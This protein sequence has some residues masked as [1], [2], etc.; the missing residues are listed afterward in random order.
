[1]IKNIKLQAALLALAAAVNLC[2]NV[3]AGYSDVLGDAAEYLSSGVT[4]AAGQELS[5][6]GGAAISWS[7]IRNNTIPDENGAYETP[8]YLRPD[9]SVITPEWFEGDIKLIADAE[10]SLNGETAFVDDVSITLKSESIPQFSA[11]ELTS[12]INIGDPESEAAAGF[13]SVRA[14]EPETNTACG[15]SE[16]F[17]RLSKNGSMALTLKCDGSKT[18]YF[19]VKLWGGDTENAMLWIVDNTTEET[20]GHIDSANTRG[21]SRNSL[22][23]RND[24]VELNSQNSETPQYGG[25]FIYSTY[26]IPRIYT[27]GREYVTIRLYSTG[28]SSDYSTPKIKEQTADSRGIY[29][30]YMGTDPCFDP[31]DFG[32]AVSGI[33]A[34]EPDTEMTPLED[35]HSTVSELFWSGVDSF[36]SWQIYGG[37]NY[38]PYM[39]GMQTRASDWRYKSYS[40]TDWKSAY[41]TSGRMLRQNITPLNMFEVFAQTYRLLP[42]GDAEKAELLDRIIKGVDFLARAQGLNGGWYSLNGWIGGGAAERTPDNPDG[43]LNAG[44][45]HLEGFGVRSAGAAVI[46]LYKEIGPYLSEMI[47]SDADGKADKTRYE[48]WEEMF[49]RAWDFYTSYDGAGHAPNQDMAQLIAALRFQYCLKLMDSDSLRSDEEIE[50]QINICLGKDLSKALSSYWV[51]PKGLILENF[52][53]VQ[54]GYSGDY[55]TNALAELSQAAEIGSAFFPENASE[56]ADTVNAAYDAAGNF[57]FTS[58]VSGAPVQYAEG[59]ISTRNS[60]YPG[61]ERYICDPYA[62]LTLNNKTSLK[63][64]YNEFAFDRIMLGTDEYSPSNAHFED[65]IVSLG[66]YLLNWDEYAAAFEEQ[67]ISEYDFISEDGDIDQYAWADEM[68]RNVVIK[69]AGETLYMALNWRSPMH[70]SSNRTVDPP[71]FYNSEGSNGEQLVYANNIGRVHHKSKGADRYGYFEVTTA[72]EYWSQSSNSSWRAV[73]YHYMDAVM[74]A[75]YGEYTIIMNSTGVTE[76]APGSE[77]PIPEALG[78]NGVYKDLISGKIYGIGG[79]FEGYETCTSVPPASTMVLVSWDNYKISLTADN[80]LKYTDKNGAEITPYP[81]PALYFNDIQTDSAVSAAQNF[82]YIDLGQPLYIKSAAIYAPEYAGGS[83][84]STGELA[85]TNSL[86]DCSQRLTVLRTSEKAD[87]KTGLKRKALKLGDTVKY[88]TLSDVTPSSTSSAERSGDD[89][90]RYLMI[91][92][93]SKQCR[94]S[95][96]EIRAD[97]TKM[98]FGACIDSFSVNGGE[99]EYSYTL[100]SVEPVNDTYFAVYDGSGALVY[101]SK[102]EPSGSAELPPDTS[103]TPKLMVWQ[104]DGM[105]PLCDSVS[106]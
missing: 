55:S 19:T 17:R 44:G 42:D 47:D 22:V 26:E 1:M 14:T 10:L 72:D 61:T 98:P 69:N 27:D 11:E 50:K 57:M 45:N 99:M 97:M 43:R 67:D 52:G 63:I 102:N 23:D 101:L 87:I 7:G 53:S 38:P 77:F 64:Q 84:Y 4:V 33:S 39:E 75:Q 68:A 73:P 106:R 74:Y 6:Y 91:F 37:S 104:K 66:N 93:W 65:N 51:S 16:T 83:G 60:H 30:V 105:R 56:Y 86:A 15:T 78:L 82:M 54:G 24:F 18:N 35:Q 103:Y 94:I 92:D 96:V 20:T 85:V 36:K 81:D 62:A 41:Y 9:G 70:T 28:P 80:F 46:E 89:M 29:A 34:T 13:D 21:P 71:T 32:E 95:E 59:L 8:Y 2:P 58:G 12:S 31:N 79:D 100:G 88:Y 49:S 3:I 48:A 25:G 40:D 90:Y 76:E 5:S